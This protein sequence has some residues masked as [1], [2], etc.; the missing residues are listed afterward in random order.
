MRG[1]GFEPAQPF[2]HKRLR[3]TRLPVPAIEPR[4]GF[5]FYHALNSLC[6]TSASWRVQMA[7][8]QEF[9]VSLPVPSLGARLC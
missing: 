4:H 8:S 9:S 5:E 6:G 3:L 2:G 1:T 7:L